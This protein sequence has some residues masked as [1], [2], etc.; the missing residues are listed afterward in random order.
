[1][2]G[3]VRFDH[4][5]EHGRWTLW[6]K[7]PPASLQPHVIELEG[8][9]ETGGAPLVR[10]E[11]P[12]SGI[13][14]ILVFEHHFS[15]FGGDGTERVRL[16]QGFVAGL[17]DQPTLV[18]SP[19]HAFC[20]QV[21]FTPLGARRILGL[22]LHEI[23]GSVVPADAVLGSAFRGLEDRLAHARDWPQR[24]AIFEGYL[25]ERLAHNAAPTPLVE[26]G[27]AQLVAAGGSLDI[28][29]LAAGLEVSRKHLGTLFR[30]EIGMTPKT[31]ARLLRFET[32]LSALRSGRVQSLA[33]LAYACGYA[34]QS[35]FNGEFRSMSG[36]SPTALLRDILPDGSLLA[37]PR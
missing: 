14:L 31:V 28:G 18:G 25:L 10:R 27:Y 9:V 6:R 5:S 12:F 2:A 34:D 23:A 35:H 22:D 30:R 20:M 21:N 32:A 4:A 37:P 24:F 16:G 19:G 26:A 8:Y 15:V 13:P 17:T 7:R 36:Q 3:I 33:D 11:L 1:M 29:A